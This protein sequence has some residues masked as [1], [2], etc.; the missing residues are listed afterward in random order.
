MEENREWS[1]AIPNNI[2]CGY[3]YVF[4]IIFSVWAAIILIGGIWFFATAKLTLPGLAINI[5]NMIITFGISATSALFLYLICDR[6]L[7]KQ[8]PKN[9]MM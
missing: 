2:I 6:A 3:F 1:D 4:F 5:F 8:S 7:I 9:N